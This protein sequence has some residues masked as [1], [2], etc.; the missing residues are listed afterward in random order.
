MKN[1]DQFYTSTRCA[2]RCFEALLGRLP[3]REQDAYFIEPSAGDGVFFDLLPRYRRTG[4]D[5]E[6]RHRGV[7]KADFF[8]WRPQGGSRSKKGKR[9]NCVVVGNP[10][11]GRR[12]STAVQFLLHAAEIADTIG[13][14]VPMCFRKFAIQKKMP[15][16]LRLVKQ[17]RL[18]RD[19]FRLPDGSPYWINTEFQ[20]WVRAKRWRN[21]R[22]MTPEPIRHP[23]FV[24]HQYNNTKQA[25]PVFDKDFDFAVPCQGWQD[26]TRKETNP[27]NCEK[28]KQ[29][30]LLLG[31]TKK[32]KSNLVAIDYERLAM[33]TATMVPGFRKCDMVMEYSEN[34][35]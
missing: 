10:P 25:L 22:R 32:Y 7:K 19:A 1:L 9:E 27:A 18:P 24:M 29:W 3:V 11:F 5:L 2:E 13:F 16:D 14:I 26:Y 23:H 34:Y 33:K 28:N 4:I 35:G 30:M 17:M 20:I 8:Q 12:G 15:E 21:R 31:M 6:P